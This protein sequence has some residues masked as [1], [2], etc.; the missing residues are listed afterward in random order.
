M[1]FLEEHKNEAGII[2]RTTRKSVEELAFFL[3]NNGIQAAAY[4]AGLSQEERKQNQ[5]AFNKDEIQVHCGHNCVW[6]G[7]CLLYVLIRPASCTVGYHGY[8]S[9]LF[10][11]FSLQES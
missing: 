2:Y 1:V 11:S 3:N 8:K 7:D 6:N 9:N 4:H 10:I 5:D